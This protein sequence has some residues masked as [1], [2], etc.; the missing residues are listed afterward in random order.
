MNRPAEIALRR[1]EPCWSSRGCQDLN[2]SSCAQICLVQN[3]GIVEGLSVE[4]PDRAAEVGASL[5]RRI[6]R[7]CARKRDATRIR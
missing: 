4:P 3:W 2:T 7:A 6:R 5:L 1:R